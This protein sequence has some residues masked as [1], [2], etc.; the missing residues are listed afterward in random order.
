MRL[1]KSK[2]ETR[3]LCNF[4]VCRSSFQVSM[5]IKNL[6]QPEGNSRQNL[7]INK[8]QR[9]AAGV[10][11]APVSVTSLDGVFRTKSTMKKCQQNCQQ[12]CQQRSTTG[13]RVE[14]KRSS[15]VLDLSSSF[16]GQKSRGEGRRFRPSPPSNSLSRTDSRRLY[17][18]S[19]FS[20]SIILPGSRFVAP[21]SPSGAC[22]VRS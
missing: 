8:H 7:A 4:F 12:N 22:P 20:A 10:A 21:D 1:A 19:A 15:S 17:P 5:D 2:D 11:H 3:I 18:G 16:F 9:I 14:S 13:V 6:P